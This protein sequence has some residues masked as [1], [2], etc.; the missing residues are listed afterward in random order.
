MISS[1]DLLIRIEG[2]Y[3][4]LRLYMWCVRLI[5]RLCI[6]KFEMRLA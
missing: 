6:F 2:Y 4:E 5:F 1:I 3:K